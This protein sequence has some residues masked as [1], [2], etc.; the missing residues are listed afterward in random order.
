MPDG[1]VTDPRRSSQGPQQ[2]G[3]RSFIHSLVH[4]FVHLLSHSFTS[5]LIHSFV[6][7]LIHSFPPQQTLLPVGP[8]VDTADAQVVAGPDIARLEFKGPAVRSYCFFTLVSIG[9]GGP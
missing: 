2:G 6:H 7:S 4:S 9:Q 5:S 8:K 3:V 1:Q